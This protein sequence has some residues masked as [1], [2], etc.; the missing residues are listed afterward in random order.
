MIHCYCDGSYSND[1]CGFGLVITDGPYS[2]GRVLYTANGVVNGKTH[3]QVGGELKA[4]MV[5]IWWLIKYDHTRAVIVYDYDGI[6]KWVTG[7]WGA[8][9]EMTKAYQI[10]MRNKIEE[11]RLLIEWRHV[12]GH[13]GHPGN[14]AADAL[15]KEATL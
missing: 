9:K 13:T 8:R 4:A 1:K 2:P 7:E 12:R 5:A 15:A 10:W 14:E 3:R 6:R 11:Y